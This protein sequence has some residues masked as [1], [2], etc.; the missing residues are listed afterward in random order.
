MGEDISKLSVSHAS[1]SGFAGGGL[2]DFFE[3]RDLG[4]SKATGGRVGAHVI[5]ALRPCSRGNST[6]RHR[7]GLDFQ[8]VYM[9]KGTAVFEYE[10]KDAVEMSEGTCFVQPPGIRHELLSCSGDCEMLEITLPAEFST[11]DA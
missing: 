11:E 10:G 1:D 6:G 9:L 4:V 2:R 3:Y 8:M 7:H 5:P